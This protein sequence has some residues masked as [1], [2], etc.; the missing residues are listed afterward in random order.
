M[1]GDY[2]D[3]YESPHGGDAGFGGTGEGIGGGGGGGP[4]GKSGGFGSGEGGSGSGSG[5]VQ[6][7]AGGALGVLL[8]NKGKIIIA[9]VAL[10]AVYFL[11]SY[12]IGD[13]MDVSFSV[14]DTEGKQIANAA[15]KVYGSG[16]ALVAQGS[17][18]SSMKIRKGEYSAEVS[19]GGYKK[20]G[21]V[22]VA[23]SGGGSI[24]LGELEKD[25]D[26]ELSGDFPKELAMG[27]QANVILK[28]K[29]N[30]SEGI[31]LELVFSGA[32]GSKYMDIGYEKPVY[33]SPGSEELELNIKVKSSGIKA[34]E[35][36]KGGVRVNG[37][38]EGMDVKYSLTEF[39]CAKVTT[40]P[41]S[42]V[43][44]GKAAGGAIVNKAIEVTNKNAAEMKGAAFTLEITSAEGNTPAVVQGWFEF[45]PSS[46]GVSVSGSSKYSVQ[47]VGKIPLDAKPEAKVLGKIRFANSYCEKALDFGMV[48]GETKVSLELQGLRDSYSVRK[49]GSTGEYS[50]D[51]ARLTLKNS[52]QVDLQDISIEIGDYESTTNWLGFSTSEFDEIKAGTSEETLM[53]F[54]IPASEAEGQAAIYLLVVE[55]ANP[56]TGRREASRHTFYIKTE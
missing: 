35:G 50:Q 11:Y 2:G 25:I 34:G 55:Y 32:L 6:E 41:A 49:S 8:E 53:A 46:D 44:F 13:V 10:V 52:G 12:F 4:W 9:A 54:G 3:K 23:V 42:K 20:Q 38:K 39:T 27:E 15:V 5:Q 47:L 1:P 26:V 56:L 31:E 22:P 18:G 48:V 29:N 51:P 16:N 36:L 45:Q 24:S 37:L 28:L 17:A 7:A 43:D 30:G 21:L 40:N 19:A 14:K 33:V